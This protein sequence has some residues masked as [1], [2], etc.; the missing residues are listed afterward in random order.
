MP[1]GFPAQ[2]APPL[3]IGFQWF[4]RKVDIEKKPLSAID[5]VRVRLWRFLFGELLLDRTS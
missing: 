2:G 1:A 5:L 4:N 3:D